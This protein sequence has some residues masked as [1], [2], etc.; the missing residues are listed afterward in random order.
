MKT[1]LKLS[2]AAA[3][4]HRPGGWLARFVIGADQRPDGSSKLLAVKPMT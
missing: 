3:L 2:L 1:Q 4:R